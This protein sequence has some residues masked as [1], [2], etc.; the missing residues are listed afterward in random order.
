M[1]EATTKHA[2][3]HHHSRAP[4]NDRSQLQV[5]ILGV[6]VLQPETKKVLLPDGRKARL[7]SGEPREIIPPHYPVIAFEAGKWQAV[8]AD[9]ETPP[10]QLAF[11]A[12]L[13]GHHDGGGKECFEGFLLDRHS[14]SFGSLVS[15]KPAIDK[16]PFAEISELVSGLVF[17]PGAENGELAEVVGLIDL[18]NAASI[19]GATHGKH[20]EHKIGL[21]NSGRRNC[22][23]MVLATFD[24]YKFGP[25]VKLQP[26]DPK[27]AAQSMDVV[28]LGPGPWRMIVANVPADEL[29]ALREE[30]P[31]PGLRLTHIELVYDLFNLHDGQPRVVPICPEEHH[32][33][34]AVVNGHCGPP[35]TGG[36]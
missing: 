19:N 33:L 7:S 12:D 24:T 35:V 34:A 25:V 30:R 23:E 18:A 36:G 22:A 2:G 3:D 29:L 31:E 10:F 9:G 16:E 21:G 1:N 4:G 26:L 15:C 17:R 5:G 32:E 20:G 28:L 14:V 11:Q 8:T 6:T 13:T 27:N